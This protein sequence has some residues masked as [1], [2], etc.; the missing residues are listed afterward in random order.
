MTSSAGDAWRPIVRDT[1][2]PVEIE[3]PP[4]RL[5]RNPPRQS[6]QDL[7][8]AFR[9]E[10][11]RRRDRSEQDLAIDDLLA[12][13]GPSSLTH[14]LTR[15]AGAAGDQ[16][17]SMR[18]RDVPREAA[19]VSSWD[20]ALD[21][22]RLGWHSGKMEQT[23]IFSGPA[24]TGKLAAA[25]A[26][27]KILLDSRATMSASRRLVIDP[28]RRPSSAVD[29]GGHPDLHLVCKELSLFSANE[30]L[31]TRRPL[32]ISRD[33]LREQV[34]GGW[35]SDERYHRPVIF[36]PGQRGRRRVFVIDEAEL[37]ESA[38]QNELVEMLERSPRDALVLLVTCFPEQLV[39]GIRSMARHVR[40]QPKSS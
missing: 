33:L 36:E 14:D 4:A 3:V 21:L 12:R 31:R 29:S 11:D 13:R 16:S 7:M 9:R 22:V 15:G 39:P 27:A 40:F 5:E 24:G 30:A 18:R 26:I 23:W 1:R 35:T 34:V 19:V 2:R 32:I 8:N 37:I 25:S 10:R 38:A 17:G 20:E 28:S 6:V